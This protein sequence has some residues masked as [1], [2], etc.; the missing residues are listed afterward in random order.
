MLEISWSYRMPVIPLML[1]TTEMPE[2]P[3]MPVCLE[4]QDCI[5]I[6]E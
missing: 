5:D 6:L 1:G 3:G 2:I 4:W